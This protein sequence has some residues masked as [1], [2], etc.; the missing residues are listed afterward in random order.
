MTALQKSEP[1]EV[2]SAEQGKLI[3]RAK[4]Y[5]K[6]EAVSEQHQRMYLFLIG[7]TLH[8]LKDCTPHGQFEDVKQKF[9]PDVERSR[10]GRAMMFAEAVNFFAKGKYP[11]IGHLVSGDR[12]LSAGEL[13]EAEKETLVVEMQKTDKGGVMKTIQAWHNKK[14]PQPKA[15]A[16]ADVAKQK[17]EAALEFVAELQAKM[18]LA[19]KSLFLSLVPEAQL[20][21]LED[22]RLELGNYIK[23]IRAR[24][25]NK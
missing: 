13:S 18:A 14:N 11:T 17:L 19:Q 7:A 21:A 16:P 24:R 9:F 1:A 15:E 5:L 22:E 6:A 8:T 2:I 23:Q 12:L 3:D 4:V 10:L 25:K 20:D